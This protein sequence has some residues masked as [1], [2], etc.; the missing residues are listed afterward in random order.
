MLHSLIALLHRKLLANNYNKSIISFIFFYRHFYPILLIS[1]YISAKC[2]RRANK[3][4]S[5]HNLR[6]NFVAYSFCHFR[7]SMHL[8]G[9]CIA[10][11]RAQQKRLWYDI[12]FRRTPPR[13]CNVISEFLGDS[14]AVLSQ[15]YIAGGRAI[16]LISGPTLSQP[17]NAIT[18]FAY[19]SRGRLAR[20]FPEERKLSRACASI[21]FRSRLQMAVQ[22]SV[23]DKI[24]VIHYIA[25]YLL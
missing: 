18:I 1:I 22:L 7:Y 3:I 4:H 12:Y 11:L 2:P 14:C 8:G 9:L 6:Q 25:P 20:L 15:K 21:G 10:M 16:S 23:S 5:R 19:C 17:K 24:A 13:W